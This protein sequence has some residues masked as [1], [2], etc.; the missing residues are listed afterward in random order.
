M[1]SVI[2]FRIKKTITPGMEKEM[3]EFLKLLKEK[4][5]AEIKDHDDI[6]Y[7]EHHLTANW[8]VYCFYGFP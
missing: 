4:Y 3:E 7:V 5:E 8:K 2:K 1:E 6:F